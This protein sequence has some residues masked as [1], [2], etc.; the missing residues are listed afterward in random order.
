[1]KKKRPIRAQRVSSGEIE[2]RSLPVWIPDHVLR[3]VDGKPAELTQEHKEAIAKEQRER[4]EWL[5]PKSGRLN[6]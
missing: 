6:S 1:M 3:G 5:K 2:A 4:E